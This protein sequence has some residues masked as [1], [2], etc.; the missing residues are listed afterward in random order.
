MINLASSTCSK[1]KDV[2]IAN[3]PIIDMLDLIDKFTGQENFDALEKSFTLLRNLTDENSILISSC[4]DDIMKIVEKSISNRN[5]PLPVRY[6]IGHIL[7]NISNLPIGVVKIC[8]N[9][10][11]L[12]LVV[13]IFYEKN[14]H[15]ITLASTT[16][17]NLLSQSGRV[18]IIERISGELF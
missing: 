14:L 12:R 1:Y 10:V 9:E 3:L 6:Q 17:R 13:E 7:V 8:A 2:I 15:L 11:L 18:M 4:G 5:L 16:L